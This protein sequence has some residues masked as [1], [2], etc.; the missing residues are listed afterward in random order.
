MVK[1]NEKNARIKRRYAQYLTE[2][3]RQAEASVDKALA[4]IDRFEQANR[5]RDFMAFHVE[6]AFALKSRLAEE[7]N[8][9]TG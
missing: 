3:K 1:H 6:E 8:S 4:A 2:A 7:L 5:R 9:S